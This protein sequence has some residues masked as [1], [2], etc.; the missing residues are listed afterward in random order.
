M[1]VFLCFYVDFIPSICS[2]S[3]GR[4]IEKSNL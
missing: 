3:A 1:I 4:D 2:F